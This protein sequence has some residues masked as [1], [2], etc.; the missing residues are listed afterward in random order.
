MIP[1]RPPASAPISWAPPP[2]R[3]ALG[4]LLL[5]SA[6]SVVIA[7]VPIVSSV[8]YPLRLFVT[9]IH[10]GSH[11]LAATLTGG[12]AFQIQ[13]MPDASGVTYTSGGWPA[14]IV[15]AG[16]IGAASYGTAMLTLARRPGTARIVLGVSGAIVAVLD[17][18]LVRNGFGL[19]W[20][21]AIAAGLL[22]AARRL[23]TKAAELTAM[24]LGVQCI[25]NS[26]YDL[27]TLVGLSTLVNGPVSDAVLMS[28]IIPLPPL[29][30]AVFWGL[31]SLG[32]LGTALRP[33]WRDTRH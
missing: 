30:W 1:N 19:G 15:M 20:G 31:L 16:Y 24:F 25:I 8:L 17:L 18:L 4:R 3:S 6:L 32:I 10:E 13:V 29:V 12:H 26:L 33:Y 23:P 27:K 21:I 22:L 2:S 28:Q 14:I 9:F 11:A 5:A 7:Q